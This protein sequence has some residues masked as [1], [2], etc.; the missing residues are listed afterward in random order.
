M[1][2]PAASLAVLLALAPFPASAEYNALERVKERGSLILGVDINNLPYSIT[3]EQ[4][5][6]FDF[7][8]AKKLAARL[9]VE[10]KPFWVGSMHGS[11]GSRL[12]RK[13][14]DGLIGVPMGSLD[15]KNKGVAYTKPYYATGFVLAVRKGGK[16]VRG[17]DDLKGKTIGIESGAVIEGLKGHVTKEYPSQETI[18]A[19]LDEGAIA[20]GYVGAV[21]AGWILKKNPRLKV[22]LLLDAPPL[23]HW[24]LA[25]AVRAEDKELKAALDRAIQEMLDKHEVEPILKKYGV[26]FFP[27]FR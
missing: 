22:E 19:A 8:I 14:C 20:A 7:E 5:P 15:G 3:E 27:P 17:F 11:Y 16:E 26:P 6:G 13:Q 1:K 2:A 18:L 12:A 10:F 9:G 25:I 21:Q 4:P 23:D 24:N